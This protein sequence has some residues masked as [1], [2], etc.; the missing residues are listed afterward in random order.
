MICIPGFAPWLP[1]GWSIKF[2]F[3][4]K[5][6]INPCSGGHQPFRHYRYFWGKP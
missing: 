5:G 4:Y 6:D 2:K 3:L 1:L